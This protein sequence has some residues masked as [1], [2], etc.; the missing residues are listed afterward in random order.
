MVGR[1]LSILFLILFLFDISQG[2]DKEML[3]KNDL[4]DKDILTKQEK[5]ANSKHNFSISTEMFSYSYKE[6]SIMKTKGNSY[7]INTTYTYCF[8][9]DFYLQP[10]LRYSKGK[11]LY[12][13]YMTGND[14]EKTPNSIF[15]MRVLLKN[16]IFLSELKIDTYPYIG[17]GYRYKKDNSF[18]HR[19]D[20]GFIGHLRKSKYY[21]IPLGLSANLNL[22]KEWSLSVLGEYD[23]F[24]R[25]IQRTYN[26]NDFAKHKQNKGYGLRSEILLNKNFNKHIFSIGPF[27]NYWK[28][29]KSKISGNICNYCGMVHDYSFEPKNTTT[30]VG[31]KIKYSF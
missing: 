21:Y 22:T 4:K 16:R 2:S 10:E 20:T 11:E 17:I 24:L 31:I 12:K 9:D 8:D 28:V 1:F 25:G 14:K 6:P 23:L 7:G 15:E 5:F 29:K 3:N 18:N 26:K 27:V 13:S 19:T 30:E